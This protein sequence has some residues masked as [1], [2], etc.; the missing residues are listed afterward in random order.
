MIAKPWIYLPKKVKFPRRKY[1]GTSEYVFG[2]TSIMMSLSDIFSV[3]SDEE[4]MKIIRMIVEGRNPIIE[5]FESPKRYYTRI[6][7][8]KNA[9]IIK[10]SGHPRIGV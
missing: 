8:L 9:S 10:K 5:D 1:I 4:S 3:L 7:K 2:F 6:S